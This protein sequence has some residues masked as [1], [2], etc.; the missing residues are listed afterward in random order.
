MHSLLAMGHMA[1]SCSAEDKYIDAMRSK[2]TGKGTCGDGKAT[3]NGVME[4]MAIQVWEV[5][6]IMEV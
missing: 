4:V 6:V 1:R 3:G 5:K 2:E